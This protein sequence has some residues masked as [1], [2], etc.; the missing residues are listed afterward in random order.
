MNPTLLSQNRLARDTRPKDAPLLNV[1]YRAG[2]LQVCFSSV[3][4]RFR[5]SGFC[6]YCDYGGNRNLTLEEAT[7]GLKEILSQ[8]KDPVREIL[9]GTF[10][11]ILDPR[12][13]SP[14]I[15][16]SVLSVVRASR[17]PTVILE[18]HSATISDPVL[19]LLQ[20]AL[21]GQELVIEM[22]LESSNPDVLENSLGKSMD[23]A[24]LERNIELIHQ[25]RMSVVLNVF[26]GA[27][28]LTPEEQV[29]DAVRSTEWAVQHGSDR[30]VLFPCNLKPN[31]LLWQLWKQGRYQRI[32]HWLL[33]E[34]LQRLPDSLLNRVELSWFGDRQQA[35]RDLYALPPVSCPEC[36]DRLMHFYQDFLADFDAT[37]R[38][39][40]LKQ[41]LDTS[42]CPCRSDF[43][44][45]LC[46]GDKYNFEMAD[47]QHSLMFQAEHR[48]SSFRDANLN[49]SRLY[50]C[51]FENCD[52]T[53][54]SFADAD[55]TGTV[56]RNCKMNHAVFSNTVL[57]GTDSGEY[58][59]SPVSDCFN[60]GLDSPFQVQNTIRQRRSTRAFDPDRTIEDSVLRRILKAG[61]Q[62][63]SPKN[64]Q[65][66]HFT[67]ITDRD[68]RSQIADLLHEKLSMLRDARKAD[69]ADCSD[70]DLAEG[71]V[72]VLRNAPVLVVVSY[73]RDEANAHG[74]QDDWPLSARQFESADLQ[75]IG[76]AIQNMLLAATEEGVDSLWMCDPLYAWPEIM[77]GLNLPTP[78]VAV[79]AFGYRLRSS[80][81]D[82]Y[83]EKVSQS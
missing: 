81:R 71:S 53:G 70:L 25:H 63:P 33:I 51:T 10:G 52:F 11:S 5:E 6:T 83:E 59:G 3:G 37:H 56:F 16:L 49:H 35:G 21:P 78:F 41:L 28:F 65:P 1:W 48:N 73:L 77:R 18:T 45:S 82:P 64:R 13:M 58:T 72:R 74:A 67:C 60:G 44:N 54:A 50:Y 46:S 22:G 14:D 15:L 17:I 30:V 12:E 43:H 75:S 24:V 39:S 69:G 47:L 7:E 29:E 66:W 42:S 79:V 36:H 19:N 38:R 26:V 40:L 80:P 20:K 4:C 55:L 31:T 62:A 2:F 76:A 8:M 23:L 27:P 32:S 68:R 9:L 57:R 61:L 34:V